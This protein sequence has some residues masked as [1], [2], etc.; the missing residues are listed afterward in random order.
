MQERG[1]VRKRRRLLRETECAFEAQRLL[2]GACRGDIGVR[3]TF[4]LRRRQ[5]IRVEREIAFGEPLRRA[6][7][8]L[9]AIRFE[10]RFV[11]GI[12]EQRMRKLKSWA[13]RTHESAFDE[14]RWIVLL[15]ADRVS[16]RVEPEL[17]T[18]HRA[19]LQGSMIEIRQVIGARENQR[20][21]GAGQEIAAGVRGAQQLV[22]KERVAVRALDARID[23]LSRQLGIERGELLRFILRERRQIERRNRA[24]AC[25]RAP[26]CADRIALRSRRHDEKDRAVR[27]DGGDLSQTRKLFRIG[28][29]N[30]LDDEE[31][32]LSLR[33]PLDELRERERSSAL[34]CCWIHGLFECRE[35]GFERRIDDVAQEDRLVEASPL[36]DE[37]STNRRGTLRRACAWIRAHQAQGECR[38]GTASR[39][40]TEVEDLSGMH[41]DIA[42]SSRARNRIDETR[43]ADARFSS[44]DDGAT[45]STRSAS[46]ECREY[47]RELGP[48]ADKWESAFIVSENAFE[49]PS[50]GRSAL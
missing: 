40:L 26:R 21:D 32:R 12:A 15:F 48:A 5:V 43:L 36:R 22:E 25:T 49:R 4:V 44:N 11:H 37:G 20:P 27:D 23:R 10:N 24:A 18:E 17:L 38:N 3:R 9:A 47:H 19:G 6:A 34:P 29:V 8:Q 50:G 28:P 35:L 46:I 41:L 30:I 14:E 13:V 2:L 33:G 39:R 31:A 42:F 7:V 16:Q 45:V 1:F